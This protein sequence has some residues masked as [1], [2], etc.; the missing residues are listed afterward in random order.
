M[1]SSGL[2]SLLSGLKNEMHATSFGFFGVGEEQLKFQG[3]FYKMSM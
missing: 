2:L 1:I 3:I